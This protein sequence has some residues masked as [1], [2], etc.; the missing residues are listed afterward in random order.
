MTAGHYTYLI[1][2]GNLPKPRVERIPRWELQRSRVP[3]HIDVLTLGKPEPLCV[4]GSW[5]PPFERH[6]RKGPENPGRPPPCSIKGDQ[7][8]SYSGPRTIPGQ[9]G[10]ERL[11]ECY[12]NSFPTSEYRYHLL[13]ER[14]CLSVGHSWVWD[15]FGTS[16]LMSKEECWR[17]ITIGK[18]LKETG[19][20]QV[21]REILRQEANVPS[22]WEFLEEA[23]ARA[24]NMTR[25]RLEVELEQRWA[26]RMVEGER[27]FFFQLLEIILDVT[28]AEQD[29]ACDDAEGI[30]L[31]KQDL[32][33][34]LAKA[35]MEAGNLHQQK[36]NVE[37]SIRHLS[38]QRCPSSSELSA[39]KAEQHEAIRSVTVAKEEASQ[40]L[41]EFIAFR[42]KVGVLHAS[43]AD[44][45]LNGET[46]HAELEVV[47]E[48]ERIAFLGSRE[49]ELLVESKVARVEV[50]QLQAKLE[51]SRAN[52]TP[53]SGLITGG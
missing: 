3:C 25:E 14:V 9:R 53:S 13:G 7:G 4:V 19:V 24:R 26:E 31:A 37:T 1:L 43:N 5:G 6:P 11:S 44:P 42:S 8:M 49:A 17:V 48:E 28:R 22:E 50:A 34:A 41:T 45:D 33:R 47:R 18:R 46:S 38:D 27:Q 30:S 10:E 23:L 2:R 21:S 32:K 16:R 35:T 15:L 20:V 12:W 39:V 52:G 40:F 36:F 51:T 29:E